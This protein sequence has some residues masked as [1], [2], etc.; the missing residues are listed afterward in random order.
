MRL[1]KFEAPVIRSFIEVLST[2]CLGGQSA[3]SCASHGPKNMATLHELAERLNC[4]RRRTNW[5]APGRS[6]ESQALA[7]RSQ[8]KRTL[9][10]HRQ[11]M[12]IRRRGESAVR[13]RRWIH[14][15]VLIVE[16]RRREVGGASG[17]FRRVGSG[18]TRAMGGRRKRGRQLP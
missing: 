18:F 1:T 16:W 12:G 6:A 4:K 8:R 15:A 5:K 11:S 3:G 2:R 14:W 10:H 7:N 17:C 13:R 9:N